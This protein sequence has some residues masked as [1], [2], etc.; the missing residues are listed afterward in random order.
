M[1]KSIVFPETND[2]TL[3][4]DEL[5]CSILKTFVLE[6]LEVELLASVALP[7]PLYGLE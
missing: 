4:M 2:G 3:P 5:S 1:L 6:M 7:D